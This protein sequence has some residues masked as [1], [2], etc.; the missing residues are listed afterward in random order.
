MIRSVAKRLLS[1]VLTS[2]AALGHL[3]GILSRR[4]VMVLMYHELRGD[5]E[6]IDAWTVM[7]RGEFLRQI[8]YLRRHYDVLTL[9]E[10]ATR[11][12][13]PRPGVVITFDDGQQGLMDVLL[14]LVE[15]EEIPVT[16][17]VTTRHIEG[18]QC[19]WFDRVINALQVAAPLE[20]D[21][22][23]LRGL[24]RFRFSG[25]SGKA[26]WV[27]IKRLLDAAVHL[28]L[29][30]CEDLAEEVE[31]QATR[32]ARRTDVRLMPLRPE[33]VAALARSRWIEIGSH[34]HCHGLF[35]FLT[36]AARN[37]SLRRS[38]ELLREWVGRDVR[39][40]AY[41]S[42][43]HDV[44]SVRDVEEFGFATAVTTMPGIW[45]D[46]TPVH[47]IP[48]V[49]VGRYDDSRVFRMAAVGGI[50][51]AGRLLFSGRGAAL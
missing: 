29:E 2:D 44:E 30:R 9:D 45:T 8:E 47:L 23:R 13:A 36:R 51:V 37:A 34:S 26:A 12:A 1:R 18:Q 5:V 25:A 22:N 16:I 49:G 15:A 41:P 48:R 21:L 50:G 43:E 32:A 7:R 17:Y 28:P 24:G 31:R 40:F 39:H 19:L 3:R 4:G 14:P 42:G 38:S 33:G 6:E 20:I 27:E 11:T 46:E 10:A 35:P